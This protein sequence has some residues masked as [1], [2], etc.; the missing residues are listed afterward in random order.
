MRRLGL[1]PLI[2]CLAIA[3]VDG[4]AWGDVKIEEQV[5]AP[6]GESSTYFLSQRGVHLACVTNKGSRSIV[7][8]DGVEGPKFDQLLL[9]NGQPYT[10]GNPPTDIDASGAGPVLFSP[11]GEHCAYCGR[12]GE[13]LV[14]MLDAKELARVPFTAMALGYVPLSFTP[15]GNHLYYMLLGQDNSGYRLIVDGKPAP[16]SAD[17]PQPV[18]SRDG[19]RYAY[20][21][22]RR[23]DRGTKFLVLDGKNAGYFGDSPGFTADGKHLLTLVSYNQEARLLV[24]G[25]TIIRA[26]EIVAVYVPPAGSLVLTV[27]RRINPGAAG[28]CFIA[29]DDKEVAGSDCVDVDQVIFSPDGKRYAAL[30][31]GPTSTKW[32]IIDGKKGEEYATFDAQLTAFTAD[33]SRFVSVANNAGR[34]FFVV[35]GVESEGFARAG[36]VRMSPQGSHLACIG[37]DD[38]GNRIILA[39]GQRIQRDPHMLVNSFVFS[40]DGSHYAFVMD[41]SPYSTLVVDG[42]DQQGFGFSPGTGQFLFS[43]DSQ[44]FAFTAK[45][46]KDKLFG[47]FIDGRQASAL[48]AEPDRMMFSADSRHLYW[49]AAEKAAD[50]SASRPVLFVDGKPAMQ[51][52]QLARALFERAPQAWQ[53]E[54]DGGLTFIA[55]SVDSIKRYRITPSVDSN[56]DTM[57][58]TAPQ[59]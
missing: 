21:A 1:I 56:I 16:A 53:L 32:M 4:R 6:V 47:I 38:R 34:V 23:E 40:G 18:F 31:T 41:G 58:S 49:V 45:R 30:C 54:P 57:L 48:K 35:D 44:H 36:G 2:L 19:S 43:P 10:K 11:D 50:P 7:I 3:A 29:A 14:I 25:K 24:D 22:T 39:E 33:S 5:L 15:Q 27:L 52:D 26:Q 51:F 13:D 59:P 20:V 9:C 8:V 55:A 46:I 42:K 17:P 37:I 28:S 12:Q